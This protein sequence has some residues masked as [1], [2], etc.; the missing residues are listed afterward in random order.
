[1]KNGYWYS[2]G[3]GS[4]KRIIKIIVSSGLHLDKK[5]VAFQAAVFLFTYFYLI[6]ITPLH[7]SLN[8]F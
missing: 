8:S 7:K 4:K 6:S 1:M 5:T 3:T 2:N